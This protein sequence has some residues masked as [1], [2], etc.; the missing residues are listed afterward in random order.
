MFDQLPNAAIM[1]ECF[2]K[3][4]QSLHVIAEAQNSL[5]I[6]IARLP[7]TPAIQLNEIIMILRT[8]EQRMQG[9]DQRMQ[10]MEQRMQSMEQR[11]QAMYYNTSCMLA[12]QKIGQPET[13]F[14]PLR[15]VTTNQE[16][17]NFPANLHMI[18]TERS[19]SSLTLYLF[20]GLT[21]C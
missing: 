18:Q 1:A 5:S 19:I 20:P 7:Q 8:M 11:M 15:D 9:M 14:Q 13:P 21:R 2:S 3:S 16:I 17:P 4:S 6:E 10:A 12:N